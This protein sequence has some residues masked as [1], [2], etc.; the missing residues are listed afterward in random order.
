MLEDLWFLRALVQ[1]PLGALLFLG[2]LWRGAAPER[3]LSGA[4]FACLSLLAIYN[5]LFARPDL[6]ESVDP[7]YL[8]LDVLLL[9][10][11]VGVA[12]RANRMFPLWMGG[13]QIA[14]LGSHLARITLPKLNPSAYAAMTQAP[15]YMHMAV[16]GLA[17]AAH[18]HREKRA[19][20]YPSWNS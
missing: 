20:G 2:A 8:V 19:G 15:N 11:I 18:V 7:I 3:L 4:L 13:V 10:V 1:V 5:R 16:L 6:F 17:L 14:A 9:V 12:L